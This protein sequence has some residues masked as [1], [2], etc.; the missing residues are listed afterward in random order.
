MVGITYVGYLLRYVFGDVVDEAL[1]IG[2]ACNKQYLSILTYCGNAIESKHRF[3]PE[4][5]VVGEKY[6][7]ERQQVEMF[8]HH[9]AVDGLE[10]FGTF[11]YDDD[12]GSV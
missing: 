3:E 7:L 6:R 5:F 4:I 10:V 11:G 2:N 8:G 1:R 9:P 12:V